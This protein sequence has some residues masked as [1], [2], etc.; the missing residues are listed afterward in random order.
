[1][2]ATV[3]QCLFDRL[4]ALIPDLARPNG[5]RTFRALAPRPGEL[6]S[7][8]TLSAIDTR[9]CDVHIAH[10]MQGH[11]TGA[12]TLSFRVDLAARRAELTAVQ[13]EWRYEVLYDEDGR[14]N[15]RQAQMND[16]AL[17]W[18]AARLACGA[19]FRPVE[20]GAA[21]ELAGECA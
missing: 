3:Y 8:C 13:D 21:E 5:E 7:Y 1:M 17:T 9:A 10:A 15:P 6:A 11:Q 12:A 14:P 2:P 18:L 16:F 19:V 20:T 4:A